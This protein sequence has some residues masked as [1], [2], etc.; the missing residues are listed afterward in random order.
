VKN[1]RIRVSRAPFFEIEGVWYADVL[2]NYYRSLD[3]DMGRL[4]RFLATS[5]PSTLVVGRRL[6]ARQCRNVLEHYGDAEQEAFAF[7]FPREHDRWG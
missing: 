4:A 2:W 6:S 7:V 1:R 3:V 5:P